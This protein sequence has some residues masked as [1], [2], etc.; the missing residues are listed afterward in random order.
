MRINPLGSKIVVERH[1]PESKSKAGIILPDTA[2]EKPRSGKVV[3]VGPGRV[4]DDGSRQT[5]SLKIGDA[6]LFPAYCGNEISFDDKQYL[7]M[8][9]ND[10][11]GTV[12]V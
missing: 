2:K 7:I 12:G 9:E 10:V 5:M 3:A 8:D 1:D 4:T 11:L 6:V